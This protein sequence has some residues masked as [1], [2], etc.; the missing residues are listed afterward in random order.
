MLYHNNYHRFRCHC[1]FTEV[2]SIG[3]GGVLE[4]DE[5]NKR[6]YKFSITDYISEFLKHDGVS[7]IGRLGVKVYH[8]TDLPT[9]LSDTLIKDLSW[10]AKGVVLKGNKRDLTDNERV[11]L[12]IFYT[13]NNE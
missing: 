9:T 12:E 13:I 4:T 11:K 5:D 3:I 6:K 1:A 7:N 10:I 8:S 2:Q